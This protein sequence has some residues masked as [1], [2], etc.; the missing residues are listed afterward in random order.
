MVFGSRQM[1]ARLVTPLVTFT[2]RELAHEHTAKDFWVLL[3]NNVT[4]DEHITK[5]VSFC[6]YCV[7]QISCTK[8]NNRFSC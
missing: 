7:S 3:G 4:C 1:H 8:H 6:T 5:T 2:G